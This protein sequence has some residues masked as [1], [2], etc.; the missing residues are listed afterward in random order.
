MVLN[1][2][3]NAASAR[4]LCEKQSWRE[5]IDFAETWHAQDPGD[6]KAHYYLAIGFSGIG[7]FSNAEAAYRRAL[8][9]NPSDPK[10]WCNLAGIL[11]ENLRKPAEGIHCIEHALKIDPAH[12]LGWA[13]LASMLGRLGYHDKALTCADRALALDPQMV[14]AHLHKGAAALALGKK[15]VVKETCDALAAIPPEKFRRAR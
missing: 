2:E 7:Q 4:K 10:V 12:K 13:N 5:L 15:E 8:Q 11:Y 14:E 3:A 1:S 9:I 6:H